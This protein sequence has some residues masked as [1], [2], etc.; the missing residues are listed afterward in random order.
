MSEISGSFA[1]ISALK[2]GAFG[3]REPP[4]AEG[5]AF[6]AVVSSIGFDTLQS[7]TRQQSQPAA[8]IGRQV[9]EPGNL[10]PIRILNQ[11]AV[12]GVQLAVS[13]PVSPLSSPVEA[14]DPRHFSGQFRFAAALTREP[15]SPL[16]RQIGRPGPQSALMATQFAGPIEPGSIARQFEA[17]DTIADPSLTANVRP[18]TALTDPAAMMNPGLTSSTI[19]SAVASVST[20]STVPLHHPRFA[21]NFAQQVTLMARDGVQQARITVNPPELGPVELRIVVRNDEAAVQLAAPNAAVRDALE[22]ALPRLREQFE[23][24]G[25]R[26]GDS[27]VFEQL[28]HNA[29]ERGHDHTD[30]DP[31]MAWHASDDS[32]VGGGG[33]TVIRHGLIDAYV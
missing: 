22:E 26:L 4:L 10:L 32:D 18:L 8:S 23:Q 24:S 28:P 29:D 7:S 14:P 16:E 33:D 21:E 25:L 9:D 30:E 27:S 3:V 1:A 20:E 17:P 31:A 6:A 19:P 15:D 2:T 5:D 11:P 12:P 13:G